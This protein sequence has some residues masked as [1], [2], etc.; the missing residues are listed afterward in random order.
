VL[1]S[2]DLV[3]RRLLIVTSLIPPAFEE[4]G[5]DSCIGL[6]G[7]W[8]GYPWPAAIIFTTVVLIACLDFG[9]Q[10]YMEN[11]YEHMLKIIVRRDGHL[12]LYKSCPSGAS[13]T[14]HPSPRADEERAEKREEPE[15]PINFALPFGSELFTFLILETGILF[16]SIIIGL[17]LGTTSSKSLVSLF[18]VLVFHQAF[19]GLGLG[20][21]LCDLKIPDGKGWIKW[22]LCG[23]YGITTPIA[24]AIGLGVRNMYD[25]DSFEASIVSGVLDS[26]S[27]GILIYTGLVELIAKDFFYGAEIKEKTGREKLFMVLCVL[28]GGFLMALLGM[29]I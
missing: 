13:L 6:T 5:P 26:V 18:I 9:L 29:W 23:L 20:A 4:I 2:E 15:K 11:A 27:A 19:E 25:A 14:V 12:L 28:L 21:R 17:N 7:G 22:A 8:K 3:K 10:Q 1:S 16:H 24:I